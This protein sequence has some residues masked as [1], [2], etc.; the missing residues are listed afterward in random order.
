MNTH[1]NPKPQ[2]ALREQ[3]LQWLVDLHS[4]DEHKADWEAYLQ[5]CETSA[6]HQRAAGAAEQL[7]EQ[8]GSALQRPAPR[9]RRMPVLGLVLVMGLACGLA[10]QGAEHGWMADQRTG[11]G[12]RRTLQLADGSRLELAPQTRVDINLEGPLRVLRLYSGE[13]YVQVAADPERPFE[14]EA[15]DGRTRALG[16]AFNVRRQAHNVHLVV[17]EHAVRVDVQANGSTQTAQVQEGQGLD[18]DVNGI[19]RPYAVDPGAETAWRNNRLVFNNRSLGD[20]LD[21]LKPYHHGLIWIRDETLRQLPVTGM[22]GTDD[23]QAQ[24]QLLQHSLPVRIRQLPW[25]TVIERDDA[26]SRPAR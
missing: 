22:V 24:L 2:P 17:T 19:S 13:L 6:E 18:Y 15:A 5:W 25:L 4:G 8:L 23:L 12:E 1:P 21:D 11:V 7:W 16:T 3:A 10:W 26:R 20:V 14:V 9:A